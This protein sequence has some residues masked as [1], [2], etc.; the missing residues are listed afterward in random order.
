MDFYL[1][2]QKKHTIEVTKK[3]DEQ[4]KA[5]F[6][7][8]GNVVRFHHR[9]ET[10]QIERMFFDYDDDR[11]SGEAVLMNMV[12]PYGKSERCWAC[13]VRI[14]EFHRLTDPEQTQTKIELIQGPEA[15]TTGKAEL[16]RIAE[17]LNQV[18]VETLTQGIYEYLYRASDRI[19][20]A[21]K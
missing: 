20:E 9:N 6:H 18:D 11:M 15:T 2:M 5:F 10:T 12:Q 8:Q 3:T 1:R 4:M 13:T 21:I 7:A 17:E 19:K 14:Q 16:M